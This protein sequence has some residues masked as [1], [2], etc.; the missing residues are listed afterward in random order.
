MSFLTESCSEKNPIR[1]YGAVHMGLLE[2]F[3]FLLKIYFDSPL[4]ALAEL[5]A[6]TQ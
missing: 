2:I 5:F 1:G 6:S 3:Q 4:S